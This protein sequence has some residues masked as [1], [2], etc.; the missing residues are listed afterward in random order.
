MAGNLSES[1]EALYT[2]IIKASHHVFTRENVHHLRKMFDAADREKK[3][4]IFAHELEEIL[5]HISDDAH[6]R[7]MQDVLERSQNQS[8]DFRGFVQLLLYQLTSNEQLR[9]MTAEEEYIRSMGIDK[10][11][12]HQ[13]DSW[14][15]HRHDRLQGSLRRDSNPELAGAKKP[16]EHSMSMSGSHRR[17]SL[18]ND[19]D[20]YKHEFG[21]DA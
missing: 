5:K 13:L 6:A 16:D 12:Q 17:A 14:R 15:Q 4:T 11:E 10:N 3:G 8:M 20:E 2:D 7:V 18:P 1:D 9:L 19:V 21:L